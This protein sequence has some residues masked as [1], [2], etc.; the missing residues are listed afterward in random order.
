MTENIKQNADQ[1]QNSIKKFDELDFIY[2]CCVWQ[3][4][5]FICLA[6]GKIRLSSA[7]I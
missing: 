4:N 3:E 2:I 1:N 6:S 7:S 5:R